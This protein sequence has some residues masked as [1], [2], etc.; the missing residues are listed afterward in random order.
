[1]DLVVE[2]GGPGTFN[3]SV[4]ALR[5]GGTLALIGVLAQ[6]SEVEI[7]PVQMRTIRVQGILVGSRE[8]FSAMNTAIALH[9]MH[10]IIDG[11]F[12]FSEFHEALKLMQAG[13]HFGK[14]VMVS[15]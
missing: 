13:G 8:D 4:A 11:T 2:V 14:I 5:R 3:Q 10:P 15:K 1:V 7:L 6:R 12:E 9:K